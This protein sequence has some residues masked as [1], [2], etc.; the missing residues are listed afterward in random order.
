MTSTTATLV[1]QNAA[2][3]TLSDAD[4]RDIYEELRQNLSLDRL[5][6]LLSSAYSKAQWRKYEIGE[7]VLNRTMRQEL[8]RAVGQSLLPPTVAEALADVDPDA[9]VWRIG[10]ETPDRIIAV[11][12]ATRGLICVDGTISHIDAQ[13]AVDPAVTKVTRATRRPCVRPF[14]T[15]AQNARRLAAGATWAQIIEAGLQAMEAQR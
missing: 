11:G 7:I 14:T 1:T 4:Y 8:R 12:R 10:D 9:Q 3:D 15:P 6:A 13:N 5:C 2:Q